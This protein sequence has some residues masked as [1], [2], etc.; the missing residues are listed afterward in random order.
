MTRVGIRELRDSLRHYLRRVSEGERIL[1]T[2][3]GRPVA[4][5]SPPNETKATQA[6]WR[7]V[8]MGLATWAGGKPRGSLDPPRLPGSTAAEVVLQDRR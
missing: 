6:A 8:E 2:R 5:L 1:I 4:L 3:R 7:L